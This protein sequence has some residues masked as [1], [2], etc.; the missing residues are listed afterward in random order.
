[1]CIFAL[2]IMVRNMISP[3]QER[4]LTFGLK[5][6]EASDC[7]PLC[8]FSQTAGAG[9]IS[10]GLERVFFWELGCWPFFSARLTR[11]CRDCAVVS[12]PVFTI[13]W[14]SGGRTFP[15]SVGTR[16]MGAI[17][18]TPESLNASLV[19]VASISDRDAAEAPTP[20]ATAPNRG[21]KLAATG[22]TSTRAAARAVL[23]PAMAD[24]KGRTA[25]SDAALLANTSALAAA[26]EIKATFKVT[27]ATTVSASAKL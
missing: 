23:T 4:N 12:A 5:A 21:M 26:L 13:D 15:N 25:A 14:K 16:V 19:E 18:L 10:E 8:S 1:M 11:F 27:S 20:L 9:L 2:C 17:L 6:R 7:Y 24:V 22:D 3:T